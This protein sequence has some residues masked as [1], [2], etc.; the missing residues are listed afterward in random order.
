MKKFLKS[1]RSYWV[2]D[3]SFILLLVVLIFTI[4]ILPMIPV[5]DDSD[6]RILNIML[7]FIFFV[8]IWSAE[9]KP[10]IFG[11]IILFLAHLILKLIRFSD[12]PFEFVILEKVVSSLNVLIFIIIN[13]KLLFRDSNFNFERVLG[14]VNVYLLIALVGAFLFEIIELTL[15]SSIKGDIELSGSNT[16]FAYYIYF[17]LTSLTTVGF[18]DLIPANHTARMLSVA[19]SAVGI[20]YPSV[21]IARLVSLGQIEMKRKKHKIKHP[22]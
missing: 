3:A 21:V 6:M 7:L 4:F 5:K 18:G 12:L 15:G 13:F 16:D 8:G 10:F 17:S 14:A 2:R 1:F 9:T 19:L 11:S 22:D 20:L